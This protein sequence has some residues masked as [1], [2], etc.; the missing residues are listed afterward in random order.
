MPSKV[1]MHNKYGGDIEQHS[2]KVLQFSSQYL[3][4]VCPRKK[5][6]P[7]QGQGLDLPPFTQYL[8]GVLEATQWT[9]RSVPGLELTLR[10]VGGDNAVREWKET[11]TQAQDPCSGLNSGQSVDEGGWPH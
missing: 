11:V 9:V 2:N 6:I 3:K 1:D 8:P 4:E 5:K 10:S 7:R